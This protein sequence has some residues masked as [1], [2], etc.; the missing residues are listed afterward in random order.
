MTH[1][2]DGKAFAKDKEELIR[3]QVNRLIKKGIR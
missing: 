2:F 1:I 3:D